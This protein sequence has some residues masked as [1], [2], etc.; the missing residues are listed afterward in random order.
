M[1]LF[2]NIFTLG[3]LVNRKTSGKFEL[4]TKMC[5]LTKKTNLNYCF[6]SLTLED[7]STKVSDVI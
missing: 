6:I 4:K 2:I 5:L 7:M 1:S 3:T